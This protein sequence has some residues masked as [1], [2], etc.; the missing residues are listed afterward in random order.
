MHGRGIRGP[1]AEAI[2]RVRA[3][4]PG[5]GRLRQATAA[6]VSLG[7]ALA[8]EYGFARLAGADAKGTLVAMILG[9]VVAMMGS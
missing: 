8:V 4:D 9:A 3:S 6:A 7:T 1:L 2:D 5:L